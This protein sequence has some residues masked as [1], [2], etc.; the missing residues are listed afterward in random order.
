MNRITKKPTRLRALL[1][2][3]LGAVAMLALAGLAVAMDG[4]G[5]RIPD[6]WEKRHGLS[7]QLDQSGR[8]QDRDGLRNRAEFRSDNDPRDRDSDDDGTRDGDEG[9]GTIASFDAETSRLVIDLFGGE[10]IAGLVNDRTKIKC[11][12]ERSD[13][14]S[15][16]RSRSHSDDDDSSDDEGDDDSDSR[17]DNSGPGSD[18]SGQ[19]GHDDNGSGANCTSADLIVGA[20]VEEADLEIEDGRA[21]FDEVELE[22]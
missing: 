3:A 4:N 7:L 11:E 16:I 1:A 5:D 2:L 10:E 22:D 14:S 8:D 18:H 19:S 21:T 13:D 17:S 15:G 20:V 12:D 9:A 6:G